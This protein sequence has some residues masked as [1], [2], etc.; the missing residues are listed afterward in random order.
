[1]GLETEFETFHRELPNLLSREGKFAVIFG[2]KV[3]GTFATFE[4]AL[5]F[6]YERCGLEPYLVKRIEIEEPEL[7]WP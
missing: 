1:M 4:D 3:I 7:V 6:G 5:S 2:D